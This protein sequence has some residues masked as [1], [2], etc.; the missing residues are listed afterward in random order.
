MYDWVPFSLQVSHYIR[1]FFFLSWPDESRSIKGPYYLD[2][3]DGGWLFLKRFIQKLLLWNILPLNTSLH[4]GWLVYKRYLLYY[5]LSWLTWQYKMINR[6]STSTRLQCHIVGAWNIS[7]S[8]IT[9]WTTK[10]R[11]SAKSV[12]YIVSEKF[13]ALGI[14]II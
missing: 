8:Q 11:K 12:R 7:W 13:P 10:N 9:A 2:I 4:N 3:I 5:I 1:D 6:H 14:I